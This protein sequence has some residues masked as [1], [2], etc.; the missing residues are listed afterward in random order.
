VSIDR[1]RTAAENL[2]QALAGYARVTTVH[3]AA[4]VTLARGRGGHHRPDR[5][6]TARHRP[7]PPTDGTGPVTTISYSM[8][9]DGSVAIASPEGPWHTAVDEDEDSWVLYAPFEEAVLVDDAWQ[10]VDYVTGFYD[11]E[12]VEA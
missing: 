4:V 7:G 1:I 9:C 12:A 11:A 10:A 3:T 6:A 5:R 8:G 2:Q